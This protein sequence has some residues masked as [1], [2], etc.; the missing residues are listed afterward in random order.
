[1]ES[2]E[3]PPLTVTNEVRTPARLSKTQK[4]QK[5]LAKNREKAKMCRERKKK[6]ISELEAQVQRLTR[7]VKR[8]RSTAAAHQP[9][10]DGRFGQTVAAFFERLERLLGEAGDQEQALAAAV[11]DAKEVIYSRE[12]VDAIQVKF[13]HTVD[14]MVPP[15]F[16][17]SET[18][19]PIHNPTSFRNIAYEKEQATHR[20]CCRYWQE[21]KPDVGQLLENLRTE[22]AAIC[23]STD[24]LYT[25]L[26]RVQPPWSARQSA[27]FSLWLGR[28]Y[29]Q[30]P[31]EKVLNYGHNSTEVLTK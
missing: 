3:S 19:L 18:S 2:H 25:Q 23:D 17:F 13:Q 1:M 26:D 7:E 16:S 12:R 9:V 27:I 30:L 10:F 31:I 11:N 5:R 28:H 6:K 4:R 15:L 24:L 8:L 14:L 21:Q 22:A 29:L 20:L